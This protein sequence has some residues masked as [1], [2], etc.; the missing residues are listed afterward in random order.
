MKKP[1]TDDRQ[2][3]RA[4][5]EALLARAPPAERQNLSPADI[6]HELQVHQIE[7]ELQ[8]EELRVA[9]DTLQASRDH[10]ADQ[11]DLAPVGYL[12]LGDSGLLTSANRTS[13]TLL[14][15]EPAKL[16]GRP[17]EDFVDG[18]DGDRWHLFFLDLVERR[19]E[20]S[21]ALRLRRG[22]GTV[23]HG[24]LVCRPNAAIE[25]GEPGSGVRIALLDV[26]DRVEAEQALHDSVALFRGMFEDHAAAKLIIDPGTG[27]IVDANQAAANF[28]GWSRERLQQMRIQEINT[29]SPTEVARE[30]ELARSLKRVYFEFRHRRADGSVRDVEVFSSR[31]DAKG[32]GLLHSIVHDITD[33][34][35]AEAAVRTSEALLLAIANSSPDSIFA[36]DLDGRW[37]FANAAALGVSGK[38]QDEVLGRTDSE[39]MN[40]EARVRELRNND[41]AVLQSG[42]SRTFEEHVEAP[43]GIRVFLSTKAPLR[44]AEGSIVGIVGVA[45]DVTDTRK[46]QQVVATTARLAAMGTLV[47][48]VAHEINNPL[49]GVLSADGFALEEVQ[50][51]RDRLRSGQPLDPVGAVRDLDEVVEALQDVQVAG[52]RIA[53]IVRDLTL[54]GRAGV[55]STRLC[56]RDVVEQARKWLP[57]SLPVIHVEVEVRDAPDVTGSAGQLAQVLLNLMTNAIRA[58][59]EGVKGVIRIDVGKGDGGTGRIDVTD[60]GVGMSPEL[61]TRIF[62]PFFTTRSTGQGMGL[63]LAIC[64]AIVTAHGGTITVTSAVG[65]GS[66]FRVELPG[67]S[68]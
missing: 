19:G 23:F 10:F 57:S 50:E 22:D 5:A 48:G 54:L 41:Q 53:Q 58:I 32:G 68:A 45:K 51:L 8:N 56:L 30:M 2:K 40:D 64:H 27:A 62:D 38:P 12:T 37:T 42:T 47:A 46:M 14:G 60:N 13:G 25:R 9:R 20:S 55:G 59:P 18:V 31:I 43:D 65:K 67:A 4:E 6:L 11:Y 35:R 28:Y 52:K 66:T 33:K 17:F 26:T 1:S 15:A 21:C 3:R 24:H 63:G 39:V 36:K 61:M 7:L 49:A 44:D 29:L 34:K 16:L